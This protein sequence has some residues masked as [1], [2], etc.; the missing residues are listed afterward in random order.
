MSVITITYHSSKT[1]KVLKSLSEYMDF[2]ISP[3]EKNEKK[4]AMPNSSKNEQPPT[5]QEFLNGMRD[6][7]EDVKQIKAGKKKG[8]QFQDLLDEL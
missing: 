1:L 4:N 6:A 2:V 3:I 8:K 7:I 5:K